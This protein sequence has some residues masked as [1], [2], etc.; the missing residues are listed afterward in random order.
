MAVNGKLIIGGVS[1][2]HMRTRIGELVSQHF[3]KSIDYFFVRGQYS[4]DNLIKLGVPCDKISIVCD[5][6][7]YL[8]QRSS[9]KSEKCSRL[10]KDSGKPTIALIFREY[11]YGQIR[12]NYI[13]NSF[14]NIYIRSPQ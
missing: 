10:I 3:F 1:L 9:S 12:K 7:F 6:A 14:Q 2:G 11:S 5:F 13:K 8:D 4:Y